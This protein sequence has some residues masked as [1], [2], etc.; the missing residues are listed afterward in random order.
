MP[1]VCSVIV[2]SWATES[3]NTTHMTAAESTIKATVKNMSVQNGHTGVKATR[4]GNQKGCPIGPGW[5]DACVQE[6][7]EHCSVPFGHLDEIWNSEVS[8]RGSSICCGSVEGHIS[9]SLQNCQRKSMQQL[10]TELVGGATE[11]S[12][13]CLPEKKTGLLHFLEY[14]KAYATVCQ[15]NRPSDGESVS[16]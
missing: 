9:S 3:E 16:R 15:S 5:N 4:T 6:S 11:E 10:C 13:F 1:L 2:F 8:R 7:N 12:L 14:Q